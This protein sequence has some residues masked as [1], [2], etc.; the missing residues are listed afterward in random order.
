MYRIIYFYIV[1]VCQVEVLVLYKIV[2]VWITKVLHKFMLRYWN[3]NETKVGNAQ[4]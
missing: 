4:T 3:Y 2:D 1:I